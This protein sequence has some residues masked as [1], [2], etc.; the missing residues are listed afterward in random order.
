M[1][2]TAAGK[3]VVD[4]RFH[5]RVEVVDVNACDNDGSYADWDAYVP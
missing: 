3:G 1:G 5:A 4:E 2:R